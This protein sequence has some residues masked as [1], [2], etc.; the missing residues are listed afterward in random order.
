MGDTHSRLLNAL[1]GRSVAVRLEPAHGCGKARDLDDK[2]TRDRISA[3]TCRESVQYWAD[4]ERL[5][6]AGARHG[7]RRAGIFVRKD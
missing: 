2:L 4:S 5:V 3:L 1:V 7:E 6:K